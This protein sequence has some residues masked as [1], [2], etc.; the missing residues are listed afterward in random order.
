[1]LDPHHSTS[2]YTH[3]LHLCLTLQNVPSMHSVVSSLGFETCFHS[4]ILCPESFIFLINDSCSSLEFAQIC[5]LSSLL[6]TPR[7]YV[8]LGDP[9]EIWAPSKP[10]FNTSSFVCYCCFLRESNEN[11]MNFSGFVFKLYLCEQLVN[12]FS[13]N[14]MWERLA[15]RNHCGGWV[16]RRMSLFLRNKEQREPK[17]K[18]NKQ[19]RRD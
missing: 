3:A 5:P 16:G 1:M 17:A 14:L 4:W 9:I 19:S 2:S 10:S 13:F 11:K 8:I 6:V 7:S 18:I 15:K 12:D